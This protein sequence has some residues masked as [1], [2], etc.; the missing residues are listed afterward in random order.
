VKESAAKKKDR[1]STGHGDPDLARVLGEAAI[2]TAR[3]G[4]FLG[5]RYRQ[6]ACRT[7]THGPATSIPT[8]CPIRDIKTGTALRMAR[9]QV[10]PGFASDAPQHEDWNAARSRWS[11]TAESR[12]MICMRSAHAAASLGSL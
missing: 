6:I 8:D 2:G 12:L 11:A 1:G 3:T 9:V 5:E 4:S 7:L 10:K